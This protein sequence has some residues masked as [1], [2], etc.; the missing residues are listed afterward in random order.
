LK[1]RPQQEQFKTETMISKIFY[2]RVAMS[3]LARVNAGFLKSRPF[4]SQCLEA[5]DKLKVAIEQYRVEK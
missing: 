4:S 2:N 1:P 3:Q 5:V